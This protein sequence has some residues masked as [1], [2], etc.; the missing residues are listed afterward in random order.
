MGKP[1]THPFPHTRWG[2]LA[3]ARNQATTKPRQE[4]MPYRDHEEQLAAMRAWRQRQKQQR[5]RREP[6]HP[7]HLRQEDIGAPVSIAGRQ[8]GWVGSDGRPTKQPPEAPRPQPQPQQSTGYDKAALV[9]SASGAQ[10]SEA[11]SRAMLK[12]SYGAMREAGLSDTLAQAILAPL[13]ELARTARKAPAA[14]REPAY[15]RFLAQAEQELRTGRNAGVW[16]TR[17]VIERAKELARAEALKRQPARL[18]DP[19]PR[20]IVA[21]PPRPAPAAVQRPPQLAWPRHQIIAALGASQAAA[22]EETA[23]QIRDLVADILRRALPPMP[24]APDYTPSQGVVTDWT[25][26]TIGTPAA[27]GAPIES[28]TT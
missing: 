5:V 4:T 9:P 3:E 8:F 16:Q 12:Q 26:P 10:H 11:N 1:A 13:R 22:R 18:P 2:K 27:L 6:S 21:P 28:P 14:P 7:A 19:E 24:P 20:L 17:D 23:Q 25:P 15:T